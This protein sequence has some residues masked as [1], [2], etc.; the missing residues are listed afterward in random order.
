MKRANDDTSDAVVK[1]ISRNDLDLLLNE[2][3]LSDDF[4]SAFHKNWQTNTAMYTKKP[5][6]DLHQHPF[7][8]SVMQKFLRNA[9]SLKGLVD[10]MQMIEWQRKQMDLYEFYQSSDLCNTILPYLSE[11]YK[12]LKLN[13]MPW[14]ERLSGIRLTHV[15]ASCSMYNSG[16]HL[17]VHDDL[18]ADRRIAYVLYLSPWPGKESWTEKMGGALELFSCDDQGQPKYPIAKAL[19]PQN[20]QF[21]FFKVCDASF[22]QVGE[23]TNFDYPRLTINGW[24]HG[25]IPPS[26]IADTTKLSNYL[27]KP[28]SFASYP[29]DESIEL[30]EWIHENYLRPNIKKSIQ[31]HVEMKSEASLGSF[32]IPEFYDIVSAQLNSGDEEIQWILQGPANQKK[33]ESL[34]MDTV[35]GPIQDLLKL[36]HSPAIFQLLHEYTELDLAGKAARKPNCTIEIHRITQNN[37]S[38]LGDPAAYGDSSLDVILFFNTKKND[39]GVISYL[40]PEECAEIDEDIDSDD[41]EEEDACD[42]D[43]ALLSVVPKDNALNLVY[44]S[45][46]TAKFLKYISKSCIPANEYVYMMTASYRE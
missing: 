13:I 15:S 44:R 19:S 33:Y 46:G 27:P 21:V 29:N 45:T 39:I 32:F 14:M 35:R 16:D 2:E 9:D 17:L 40:N 31:Q 26:E 30:S 25:P 43:A 11:F 28:G 18:L 41:E 10:E 22:H 34:C 36:F 4:V 38:L 12:Q 6:V 37:Y 20:N 5:T 7:K 24:F 42:K 1:K 3:L 23:V 8:I